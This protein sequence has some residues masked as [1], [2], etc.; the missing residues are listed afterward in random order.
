MVRSSVLATSAGPGTSLCRQ[1]IHILL[2]LWL[3][4]G[5]LIAGGG[6]SSHVLGWMHTELAGVGQCPMLPLQAGVKRR[7]G[8]TQE[9][10]KS[11]S[12]VCAKHDGWL[13]V[14]KNLVKQTKLS[15][16]CNARFGLAIFWPCY[17]SPLLYLNCATTHQEAPLAH[18]RT[19]PTHKGI[20]DLFVK[21]APIAIFGNSFSHTSECKYLLNLL[22]TAP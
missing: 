3:L 16:S 6:L 1:N 8:C 15:Q 20:L 17:I 13:H 11:R 9:A 10:R 19:L 18:L 21:V 5:H 14:E 7:L 2:H 22:T 4:R 12:K